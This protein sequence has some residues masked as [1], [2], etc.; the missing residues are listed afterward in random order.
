M[1][2]LRSL[3]ALGLA[4]L[5]AVAAGCG[6]SGGQSESQGPYGYDASQPLGFHDTG[7]ANKNYPIV[8]RNV[9]Y[10]SGKD[11]V[12]AYLLLPPAASDNKKRAAV[13]YLHGS[14][15]DRN[16]L[17]LPATWMAGR[18]AIGLA[19]TAPSA[20]A[21]A[22]RGSATAELKHDVDLEKRDV[23][24][25]RRGIDLLR[26]R[27]DV[28]PNRIG[29]VGWSAGARTGGILAGV[30]PRLRTLVLMSGGA[31]PVKTYVSLA[32][33]QIRGTVRHYLSI[34][35]PLHY[36]QNAKGSTL[37]LQDGTVD[38]SVPRSALLAFDHAA[39]KGAT[40]RWYPADHPLNANAY[41]D[42]LAWLGNKLRITDQPI[43]G[44]L[45][46]PS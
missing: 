35:D 12:P 45:T 43:P 7:R 41:L 6:G 9:S 39:P 21:P 16:T 46:G 19:I 15:G 20:T 17:L 32:P 33:K 40:V 11:R 3:T 24:A 25:V 13:I 26:S 5:V 14:G 36:L 31:V 23:I 44:A 42:Q 18:G 10:Q 4:A 22:A 30:E 2:I 29:F 27:K 34:V 28:D 37:L 8:I 38:Q 1:R